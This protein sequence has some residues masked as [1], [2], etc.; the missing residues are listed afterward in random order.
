LLPWLLPEITIGEVL[1]QGVFGVLL[2]DKCP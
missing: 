1:R 2:A